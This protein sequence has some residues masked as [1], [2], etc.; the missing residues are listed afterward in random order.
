MTYKK[1]QNAA[2][3]CKFLFA[4]YIKTESETNQGFD[5]LHE[6]HIGV[7]NNYFIHC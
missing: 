7:S 5:V 3:Y 2:M 4:K 1:H 6:V